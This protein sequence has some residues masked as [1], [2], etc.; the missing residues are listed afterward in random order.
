VT[1]DEVG[2]RDVV[3]RALDTIDEITEAMR[4]HHEKEK[5]G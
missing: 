4:E 3:V 5:Q 1:R 2:K